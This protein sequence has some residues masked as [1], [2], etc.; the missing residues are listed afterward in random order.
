MSSSEV[1][2]WSHGSPLSTNARPF[3]YYL[4]FRISKTKKENPFTPETRCTLGFE[5]AGGREKY[6]HALN[7]ACGF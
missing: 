6:F 5:A 4:H 3:C 7:F 1:S 2:S